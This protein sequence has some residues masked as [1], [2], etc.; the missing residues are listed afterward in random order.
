MMRRL[1]AAEIDAA[2]IHYA[3]RYGEPIGEPTE[4]VF[5]EWARVKFARRP[6][7]RAA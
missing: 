2:F 6:I 3:E 7:R 1:S 4:H 5:L